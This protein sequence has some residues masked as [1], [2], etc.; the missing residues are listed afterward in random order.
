VDKK[1]EARIAVN[2]AVIIHS[3]CT[4]SGSHGLLSQ[5]QTQ[6]PAAMQQ[7]FVLYA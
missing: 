1:L 5:Q 4:G 3:L 6:K 2:Y 7:A